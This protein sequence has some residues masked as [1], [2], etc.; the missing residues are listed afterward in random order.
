MALQKKHLRT[1]LT[2]GF[3]ERSNQSGGRYYRK[4]GKPNVIQKGINFFDQLSW[5]HTMLSMPGWKFWLWLIIPYIV[6]NALFAFIYYSIGVEHLD[7]MRPGSH[8]HNYIESFFFSFQ[9][10][11]TVG[12]GHVSPEGTLTSSVAAFE[13]FLGV[14][15]LAL[16][17]GLFYGRFSRPRSFL[18]FSDIALIAPYKDGRALMFRTTPYKNNLLIDAEVKLTMGMRVLRNGEEKNE[19]YTLG[20][21]FSKINALLLNWTIVHPIDENSPMY[22]LSLDELR[23]AR[24]EVIV[25]LK[26]FDEGFANTVVA[27]TSYTADEMIEGGKFK[28]MYGPSPDGNATVLYIDKLNDYEKVKL[29]E[30]KLVESL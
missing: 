30:L 20:V 4:D 23:A 12:Y 6:V 3:G 17:A 8:W 10:F 14:L 28:P 25:F 22:G 13:S 26:A 7:G 29:P 5:Y 1:E 11:T 16:A 18:R 2:T 24:A 15:T 27:R 19:F 21:E 9:T